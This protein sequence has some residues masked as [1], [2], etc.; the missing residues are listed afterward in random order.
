MIPGSGDATTIVLLHGSV[1][2]NVRTGLFKMLR[3]LTP[4]S[5]ALQPG[6]APVGTV[7]NSFAVLSIGPLWHRAQT[8]FLLGGSQGASTKNS[9]PRRS[10]ALWPSGKSG[11][12]P[13]SANDFSALLEKNRLSVR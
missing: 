3:E 7:V 1:T 13:P 6:G 4:I 5:N 11:A 12:G 9:R 2:A 10:D 8:P